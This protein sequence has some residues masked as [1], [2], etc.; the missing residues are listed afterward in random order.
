MQ[1][2]ILCGGQG[3]RLREET[4][5]RPKPLVEIGGKPILWHIMKLYAHYGLREFVL[6]LGYRG[7]MIKE[8]F[9]NYEAMNNDFTVAL[10]RENHITFHEA[11]DEQ[12]F[13]VTLAETG[14]TTMTGG[15]VKRI[16]KYI[17]DD[18]FMVTYGDGLANLD[19]R[20]LLGF[21][22]AHGRLATLTTVRPTSRF[23]VLDLDADGK[24]VNFAEKP[25]VDGWVSAGFM[26][27]NRRLFD[28]L[29]GD[30]CVLEREP[31]E[32]LAREGQLMAYQHAGFFYAMDTF[33]EYK[34]LNELWNRGSAP[35]SVWQ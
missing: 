16:Q 1:V 9:L 17:S 6:C 10:G 27:F 12:N 18:T 7:N 2:V 21:H 28:Y 30:D 26:V 8:Y 15:R 31:L 34:Y 35:W 25:Q 5:Y 13:Q 22:G 32:H 4:E 14:L 19:M 29:S 33:R 11:H 24:V 20:A 23:G 3:T